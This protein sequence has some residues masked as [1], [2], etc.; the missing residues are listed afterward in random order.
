MSTPN[1]DQKAAADAFLDFML[2]DAKYA[3][4][5]GPAGTGK[6][7]LM[8]YLSNH[9]LKM[10]EDAYIL[11]DEKA[12][13]YQVDFAATT[14]KAAEV[15]STSLGRTVGTIHSHLGLKIKP[16]FRTG[17][18]DLIK[19]NN[20]HVRYNRVTFIDEASTIDRALLAFIDEAFEDSKIIFVGDH[21]QMAPVN[22]DVS[23]CFSI[24]EPKNLYNLTTPVRNAET[25]A[26]MALCQ[27][28]RE[29]VETGI[30][31]PVEPVEGIIEYLSPELMQQGLNIIF[32][33][34]DPSCR[35][36]NYTN[37][38][39]RDYN[40]HIREDVRKLPDH[41]TVGEA[42]VVGQAYAYGKLTFSVEQQLS[43]SY[44][45]DET[46]MYFPYID[47]PIKARRVGFGD[48]GEPEPDSSFFGAY[49]CTQP[50]AFKF[51][52]DE[53]KR[54]KDWHSFYDLKDRFLDIRDK[55]ACTVYKS[56]GSTY[57]FLFIDIGNI[58]TSFDAQQVARMLYVAV[59]RAK[60]RVYFYG[61]LPSRYHNSQGV[62]LWNPE[63]GLNALQQ[64][65]SSTTEA[66]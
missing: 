5:T 1:A 43:I 42:V 9:G 2:S 15:L 8:N 20:F 11:M 32:A 59:S 27:Q 48:Q 40:T 37:E 45:G 30:F 51:Y 14:N 13:D 22:E 33:D 21:A 25:P 56:Q 60:Y 12:V 41:L 28:L 54:K 55:A 3:A 58:G 46:E 35:V 38:R 47:G 49:V 16:N 39:V 34:A 66:A 44:V 29:T 64:N 26:L 63:N 31:K 61:E 65:S 62:P 18:T 24:V 17:K 4:I 50:A 53:L 23:P 10:Y 7:Y 19:G 6:T 52:L 36:L 57:D